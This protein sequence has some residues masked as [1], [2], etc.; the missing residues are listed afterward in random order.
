M[1]ETVRTWVVLRLIHRASAALIIG[2]LGLG[3]YMVQFVDDPAY[4]F[5]LTQTHKSIA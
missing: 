5:D 4:R 1:N 2:A 3:T